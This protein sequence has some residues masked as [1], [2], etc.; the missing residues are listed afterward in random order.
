MNPN[1]FS[2]FS[3]LVSSGSHQISGSFSDICNWIRTAALENISPAAA[4][5]FLG[6]ATLPPAAWYYCDRVLIKGY[7]KEIIGVVARY[8]RTRDAD[9][10]YKDL[11]SMKYRPILRSDRNKYAINMATALI[12]TGQPKEAMESLNRIK[13]ADRETKDMVRHQRKEILKTLSG[14]GKEE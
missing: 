5:L 6:I 14:I 9:Q 8:N 1:F 3:S 12:Y 4:A 13:D 2:I 7:R 10:L 11:R